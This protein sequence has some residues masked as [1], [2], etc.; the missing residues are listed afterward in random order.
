MAWDL[1][2]FLPSLMTNS[3]NR[4]SAWPGFELGLGPI[5]KIFW[6]IPRNFDQI[7]RFLKIPQIFWKCVCIKI[8]WKNPQN[9]VQLA[10]PKF[11]K[12]FVRFLWEIG[13]IQ[14]L[15]IFLRICWCSYLEKILGIFSRNFDK[16]TFSKNLRNFQKSENFVKIQRNFLKNFIDRTKPRTVL[17]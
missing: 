17:P 7:L 11:V 5:N 1:K 2:R 16:N 13:R 14:I 8:P 12:K 15:R 9:F 4:M 6:K 3:T 10:A